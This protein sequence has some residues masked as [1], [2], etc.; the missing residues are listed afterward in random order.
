M[1]FSH[2]PVLLGPCLEGLAIRPE[3]IYVDA[4]AG[5]GG[6]SFAIVQ[7][8]TT[9]R[10]IALDKDPDAVQA[11]AQR[12][13]AFPNATVLHTEY[14]EMDSALD[15]I[16]VGKVN[17]VL[18]DIGVSSYQ[19]DTPERGFSYHVDAPLDMRMSQ[20]GLSAWD[21]VNSFSEKEL[22]RI[23]WEY[24]E[25]KCAGSIARKLCAVRQQKTIDTTLELAELIKSAVPAK[26][27]KDKNPA[28]RSFQ[29]NS[30]CREQRIG[31]PAARIG[32]RF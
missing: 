9:G 3:G 30:Y 18:M 10:L 27:R 6:H 8:L 4:T 25:E 31:Q 28:K 21:V 20:Q 15:S 5:G 32:L 2:I 29:G 24:G 13:S 7:C 1:A 22:A 19:L 17:G 23:L 12:L 26:M 11:A 16:G 14:A